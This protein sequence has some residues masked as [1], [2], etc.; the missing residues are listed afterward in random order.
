VTPV[1]R[2]GVAN[3]LRFRRTDETIVDVVVTHDATDRRNVQRTFPVC[4][5][6]RH[7]E[8]DAIVRIAG[9]SGDPDGGTVTA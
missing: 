6:D 8:A 9:L 2:K 5:A 4:D 7:V 1:S 3:N